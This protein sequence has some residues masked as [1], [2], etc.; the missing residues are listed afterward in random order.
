MSDSTM[1]VVAIWRPADHAGYRIG[2]DAATWAGKRNNLIN[3]FSSTKV[4]EGRIYVVWLHHCDSG[5]GYKRV[6]K[7]H[8]DLKKYTKSIMLSG[9]IFGYRS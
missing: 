2:Q 7:Y 9:I 4:A 6:S 3:T 8:L 5:M 1:M